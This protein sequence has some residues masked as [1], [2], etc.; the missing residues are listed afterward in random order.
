MQRIVAFILLLFLPAL[1]NGQGQ[2]IKVRL[3]NAAGK[4]KTVSGTVENVDFASWQAKIKT[5]DNK[6]ITFNFAKIN[7]TSAYNVLLALA[8][9]K[10]K[11]LFE[12]AKVLVFLNKLDA[13][14]KM[15]KRALDAGFDDK[16]QLKAFEK[17]F[18]EFRAQ[19]YIKKIKHALSEG[20]LKDAKKYFNKLKN[21]RFANTLAKNKLDELAQLIART[22]KNLKPVNVQPTKDPFA[23]YRKA[24]AQ[25]EQYLKDGHEV[26]W[27]TQNSNA[28]TPWRKARKILEK[29]LATI[30]KLIASASESQQKKELVEMQNRAEKIL[31]ALYKSMLQFYIS[32]LAFTS[33]REIFDK[34]LILA[35]LDREL[36]FYRYL[37]D[38]YKPIIRSLKPADTNTDKKKKKDN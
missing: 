22:E 27:Q 33:A 38:K 35:P 19:D 26:Y 31:S 7:P 12:A 11:N 29:T 4:I 25:A 1:N 16:A 15:Y 28:L 10:A 30:N 9:G 5:A 23:K 3:V 32:Q 13:A 21:K 37:Y 36:L 18:T 6:I 20:K 14:Y 17:D 8:E 24:I 2:R 34:A